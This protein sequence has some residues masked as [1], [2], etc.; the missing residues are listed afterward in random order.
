MATRIWIGGA[1]EVAQVTSWT[2]A[3]TWEATDIV[4][5][6]IGTHTVSVVTGSTT[7]ATLLTTIVTALN[8]STIP[9]FAEITWGGTSPALTATA[10]TAGVPFTVTI[11]TTETGGGAADSQTIDGST[12]STGTDTTA[13]SGPNFANVAANWSGATA[14]VDSDDIVFADSEV[15]VLYG[16]ANSAVSP[17]SITI[18]QSYT[19]NIG[20]PT[21]NE[22]ASNG[23]SYYEYRNRYLQYGTSGDAVNCAVTIGRG[24]GSGSPRV[25]L[26]TGSGQA[27]IVVMNSGTAETNAKGAILW[28][29]THASNTVTINKGSLAAATYPGE[30]A[31]I[32]TLKVGYQTN[33]QGDASVVCSS[34]VTLTTVSQSGGTLQTESN[35]TTGSVTDG[36]WRFLAGTLTTLNL[37]GGAVRYRSTGTLTTANVGSNGNLDFRQDMRARTVT[38]VNLYEGS[39]WH[40]PF[41]TVTATNGYDFIR[42]TPADCIWEVGP[43]QTWT[44]SAI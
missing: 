21:Y 9:E 1:G 43:H 30:T 17:A 41:S 29:G 19:G 12:S 16:M 11:S 25:L 39:E 5:I 15:D 38:N 24:E 4:N 7:I 6:T 18:D 42:C 34:G 40:D 8:A 44:P 22:T 10:D 35:V 31:T 37:D 3:G 27:T 36:D 28:K 33:V 13:C 26:D 23:A 2:F 14:P 32:A 20:L